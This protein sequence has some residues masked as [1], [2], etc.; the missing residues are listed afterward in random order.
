MSRRNGVC[1][2]LPDA[3]NRRCRCSSC[4]VSWP[5]VQTWP[6]YYCRAGKNERNFILTGFWCA[7]RQRL[8][9]TF[10]VLFRVVLRND[11][12]DDSSKN[13]EASKDPYSYAHPFVVDHRDFVRVL[14]GSD[15]GAFTT[16]GSQVDNGWTQDKQAIKFELSKYI[17]C[18]IRNKLTTIVYN[19]L[20]CF[21]KNFQQLW[22]GSTWYHLSLGRRLGILWQT[23]FRW[24]RS[25]RKC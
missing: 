1:A 13:D 23:L 5:T 19:M 25:S 17:F 6:R 20:S 7:D 15:F 8:V 9:R 18:L 2:G 21:W 10:F 22:Y 16:L 4:R 24:R 3:V 12:D 14:R 11:D